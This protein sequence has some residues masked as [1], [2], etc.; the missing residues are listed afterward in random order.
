MM[1]KKNFSTPIVILTVVF[2][3]H[4]VFAVYKTGIYIKLLTI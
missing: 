2:S 1:S 3:R 4:L